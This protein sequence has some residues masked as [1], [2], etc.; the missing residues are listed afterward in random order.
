MKSHRNLFE[1]KIIYD[2][3]IFQKQPE[4]VLITLYFKPSKE[5]SL[6]V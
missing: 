5:N 1:E 2:G 3:A 6:G 4:K